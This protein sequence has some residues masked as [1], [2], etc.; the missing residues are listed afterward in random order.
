VCSI[1]MLYLHRWTGTHVSAFVCTSCPVSRIAL[2]TPL[3]LRFSEMPSS[4]Q[5]FRRQHPCTRLSRELEVFLVV[6]WLGL[7][8]SQQEQT[9]AECVIPSGIT[10][11][12]LACWPLSASIQS[13]CI[14]SGCLVG[15]WLVCYAIP[16]AAYADRSKIRDGRC[17]R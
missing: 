4:H 12:P 14:V 8:S 5:L 17:G 16:A 6:P 2:S 9:P 15:Q 10:S 11:S 3:A 7:F 1:Q 13:W